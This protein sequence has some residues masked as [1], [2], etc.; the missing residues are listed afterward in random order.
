MHQHGIFSLLLIKKLL[1]SFSQKSAKDHFN[2][3][4]K[5]MIFNKETFQIVKKPK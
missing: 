1:S 4:F 5:N 3:F 2:L